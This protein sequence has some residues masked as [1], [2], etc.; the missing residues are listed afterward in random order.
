MRN[1]HDAANTG[2]HVK[3]IKNTMPDFTVD[4]HTHIDHDHPFLPPHVSKQTTVTDVR[5][6]TV[7]SV[8]PSMVSNSHSSGRPGAPHVPHPA[9]R[10]LPQSPL[11]FGPHVAAPVAY[12]HPPIAY[13]HP[14]VAYAHA[15][16]AGYPAYAH[17]PVMAAAPRPAFAAG[18]AGYAGGYP[19]GFVS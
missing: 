15:P 2:A 7:D 11:G 18:Y 10:I 17:P 12:A 16:V 5:P 6:N 14:P 9:P 1:L 3:D 19:S 8:G 4:E 13:A